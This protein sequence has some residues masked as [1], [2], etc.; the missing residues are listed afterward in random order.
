MK[1]QLVF[2]QIVE[3]CVEVFIADF[4]IKLMREDISKPVV[5]SDSM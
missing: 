4:S 5:G 2:V 3:Y 1:K